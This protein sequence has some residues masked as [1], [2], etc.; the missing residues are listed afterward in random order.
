MGAGVLG[1]VP[2]PDAPGA[3]AADDFALVRVDDNIIRRGPVVIATLDGAGSRLP[4]LHGA[5]L[6]ARHHPLALAVKRDAC[7]VPGV[8]FEDK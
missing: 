7:D 2:Q 1:E 4:D 5:V 6:G 8:T 3:I